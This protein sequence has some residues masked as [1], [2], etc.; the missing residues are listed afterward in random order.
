MP[1][2]RKKPL[3]QIELTTETDGNRLASIRKAKG[4]TQK[5]LCE[6]IG[7]GQTLL[8]AYEVGRL[9]LSADMVKRIALALDVSTDEILGLQPSKA[10]PLMAT[11]ARRLRKIETLPASQR[12]V[13]VKTIDMFLKGVKAS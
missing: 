12:K 3:P 2:K 7:I 5:Q 11:L 8:S 13:L 10:N 9:S 6:K 4:F 1:Q